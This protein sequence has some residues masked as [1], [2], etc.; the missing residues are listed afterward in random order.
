MVTNPLGAEDYRSKHDKY[1]VFNNPGRAF[2]TRT[3]EPPKIARGEVIN[4][5]NSSIRAV[6][7]STENQGI[8]R[9]EH[10]RIIAL[11]P[12]NRQRNRIACNRTST[13]LVPACTA[14]VVHPLGFTM[15]QFGHLS[16]PR[17]Q[18]P[19][20][21]TWWGRCGPRHFLFDTFPYSSACFRLSFDVKSLTASTSPPPPPPHSTSFLGVWVQLQCV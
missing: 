3:Q 15:L 20:P 6:Q 13:T 5:S 12:D 17:P 19:L 1:G 18:H 7:T 8:S 11:L 10:K 21:P 4:P 2:C 16:Y 14:C 9:T